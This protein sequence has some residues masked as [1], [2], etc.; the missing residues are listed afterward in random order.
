MPALSPIASVPVSR[1]SPEDREKD[2]D[3][4]LTWMRSKKDDSNDPTGAFKKIDQLL[5]K[6]RGQSPEDRARDIEA[7]LDWMRNTGVEPIE[8]SSLPA[9]SKVGSLPISRRSPEERSRDVDSVMTWMRNGKSDS[10][11]PTGE[12]KKINQMLPAKGS[13]G[14]EDRA[15]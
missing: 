9:L 13:Q 12:F 15:R 14:P 8:D 3:A 1:R 2:I 6:K 11:D 5:P 7:A 10:D 4:I